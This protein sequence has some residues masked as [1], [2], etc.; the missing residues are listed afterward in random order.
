[1]KPKN[2]LKREREKRSLPPARLPVG[3]E[4]RERPERWPDEGERRR[5]K[6]SSVS[7]KNGGGKTFNEEEE[8]NLLG[9]VCGVKTASFLSNRT[10]ARLLR[11]DDMPFDH[12]SER[13]VV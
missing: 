3:E 2:A 12:A 13:Q 7:N 11:T 10:T 6:S 8:R 4:E 1:M 9:W 5:E